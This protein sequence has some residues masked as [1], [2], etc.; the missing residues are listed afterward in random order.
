MN[1]DTKKRTTA[2]AGVGRPETLAVDWVSDNVYYFDNK[3]VPAIKVR[4]LNLMVF[5]SQED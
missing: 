5:S 2:S 4:K 3:Q 1:I